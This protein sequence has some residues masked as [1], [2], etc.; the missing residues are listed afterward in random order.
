MKRIIVSAVAA[1]AVLLPPAAA[2]ANS[3]AQHFEFDV[4]EEVLAT[5]PSGTYTITAGSIAIV[6]HEGWPPTA[7][8][9]SPSPNALG[10][11]SW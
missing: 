4:T 10:A 11:W 6:L 1:V 9:T 7:T 3:P 5:C 2:Q 8:R